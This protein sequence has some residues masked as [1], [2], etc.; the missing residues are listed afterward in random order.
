MSGPKSRPDGS[1]TLRPPHRDDSLEPNPSPRELHSE[2]P[3]GN[4]SNLS[5]ERA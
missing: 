2:V 4:A 5:S 3:P 1:G